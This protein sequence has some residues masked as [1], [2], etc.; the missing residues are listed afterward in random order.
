MLSEGNMVFK[1]YINT[2]NGKSHQFVHMFLFGVIT[3]SLLCLLPTMV[4]AVQPDINTILMKST[5]R[6]VGENGKVGTVFILAKPVSTGGNYNVLVTAAHVLEDMTGDSAII[7]LRRKEGDKY[8]KTPYLYQIR[9]DG[10][11]L[12]VKHLNA[13][14]A[15]MFIY[16]PKDIDIY[17]ATTEL[18]ATDDILE[19][20]EIY[21][22]RELKVLGF[23]FSFECNTS[24]FPVLRTGSIA[25][26]PLLPT[27]EQKTF[28]MD[29]RVFEGNSGGPVYFHDTNWHKR[30]SGAITAPVEVQMILGLV[31]EQKVITETTRSYMQESKQKYQLSIAVV[32]HAALIKETIN[33]LPLKP[34]PGAISLPLR[35]MSFLNSAMSRLQEKVPEDSLHQLNS[36]TT[37]WEESPTEGNWNKASET[38]T[39][40]AT[41]YSITSTLT[42]VSLPRSGA[43]IK[44][45]TVG[46]RERKEIPTT[47]KQVTTCVET[48][49]IGRYHIWAEREGKRMSD[50]SHIYEIVKPEEKV[51]ISEDAASGK[52]K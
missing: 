49:P 7:F 42:V 35:Q 23:P 31:S 36:E 10:R 34:V 40:T 27:R 17:L 8:I 26:F 19:Q 33:L 29:F 48:V 30:G 2:Q 43:T 45:Q 16:L 5:Y 3:L 25:S 4:A 41:K 12:W 18:L 15:A 46:Q 50:I 20:Y 38:V 9:Q 6:I 39:F 32:V 21:P 47:A 51:E 28:L 14:V 24:G 52:P 13:D 37:L 44:Y 11:P 22:G 1:P